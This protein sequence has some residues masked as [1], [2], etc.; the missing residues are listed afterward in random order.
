[1]LYIHQREYGEYIRGLLLPSG[2]RY[3]DYVVYAGSWSFSGG[4]PVIND[5][6]SPRSGR[7]EELER[8]ADYIV[9]KLK[10]AHRGIKWVPMT[11][12]GA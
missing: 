2:D 5:T 12:D 7:Y 6:Y 10:V 11:A 9:Y 4:D 1:M 8:S 3:P